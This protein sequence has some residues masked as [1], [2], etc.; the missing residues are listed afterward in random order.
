[1]GNFGVLITQNYATGQFVI[2]SAPLEAKYFDYLD[3]LKSRDD[4]DNETSEED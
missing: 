4:D 2:N 3:K 1:M